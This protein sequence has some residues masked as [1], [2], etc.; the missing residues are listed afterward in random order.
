MNDLQDISHDSLRHAGGVAGCVAVETRYG[1]ECLRDTR[2]RQS[3]TN[4]V[5]AVFQHVLQEHFNSRDTYLLT[6]TRAA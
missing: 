2:N 6:P 3:A 5:A 1:Q 4:L